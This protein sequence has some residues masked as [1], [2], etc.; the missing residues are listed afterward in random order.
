MDAPS[1]SPV[2]EEKLDEYDPDT[3]VEF[4]TDEVITVTAEEILEAVKL[5]GLTL[6]RGGWFGKEGT[7]VPYKDSGS[8]INIRVTTSACI[9]GQ[10]AINLGITGESLARALNDIEVEI[11]TR[12]LNPVGYD[13]K[14]GNYIME[15]N[16]STQTQYRWM[17]VAL[18]NALKKALTDDRKFRVVTEAHF[19]QRKGTKTIS[20]IGRKR[21]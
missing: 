5:N 11:P 10:G 9:L 6:R 18:K 1:I 12:Q 16:D 15:L 19:I 17:L 3:I 8:P 7:T 2:I 14:L 20:V 4:S 21:G 13:G